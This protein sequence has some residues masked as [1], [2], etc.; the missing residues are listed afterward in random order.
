MSQPAAEKCEHCDAR[1]REH[2][3]LWTI[4][5]PGY[6]GRPVEE[7]GPD[8]GVLRLWNG[9]ALAGVICNNCWVEGKRFKAIQGREIRP[10]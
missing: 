5:S 9:S 3:V 1:I 8:W 2:S 4:T 10:V 6:P 7:D